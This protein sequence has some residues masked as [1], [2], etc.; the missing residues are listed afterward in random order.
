MT[1]RTNAEWLTALKSGGEAQAVALSELRT[2]LLRAA[3]YA[4]SRK[5]GTLRDFAPTDIN[6][7]TE[8]CTQE[9]LSTI[10]GHLDE[11]RGE[12]RFTTW[13]YTFAVNAALVA[14]RR[15]RWGRVR[16]DRLLDT[17]GLS[18]RIGSFPAAA[19][20]PQR[21]AL[22]GQI[23]AAIQEGIDG[24]LTERQRQALTAVVFE[25]VP[26][27]ELARHW[28]SNRNALYK[29][30]HDARRKL[31]THLTARGFDTKEVLDA[32]SDDT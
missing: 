3:R 30:L 13:A 17:A 2:Y 19:S 10:L 1:P 32:F 26:L 8:D 14:A 28:G 5:R 31:K 21:R 16:L 22:Q 20:N 7:L 6:A 29:L 27:D 23:V 15:E 4:L 24:H 11:F 25:D 9:T 18:E 12:S